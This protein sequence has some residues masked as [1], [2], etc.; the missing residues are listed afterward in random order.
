MKPLHLVYL[1]AA[2]AIALTQP[3]SVLAQGSLTPPGA[4]APT[5]KRLDEVEPRVNLQAVP[6]PTG[7]DS[8]N[9]NYHFIINQPGSYYLSA[10]LGATKANG[11]KINVEGVTLDLNGFEI[12][13]ASG[14]GG[15][16]IEIAATAHRTSLRHGSIKGFLTG[17][18]TVGSAS[19]CSLQGLSVGACMAVGIMAGPSAVLDS[20]RAHDNFQQGIIAGNSATLNN[21]TVTSNFGPAGLQTGSGVTLTNCTA[22]LNLGQDAILAGDGSSIS[23]CSAFNNNGGTSNGI[24]AGPGSTITACSSSNNAGSGFNLGTGGTIQKC[25]A[26][27][28]KADGITLSSGSAARDNDCFSNRASGGSGTGIHATGSDNRI[29]GNNLVNNDRGIDV[30]A[31]NNLIVRNSARRNTTNYDIVAN[32]VYGGIID[33]TAPASA[34]V[35]GNS[36]ATSAGTLDPWANVS[37]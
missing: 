13:R 36:A 24:T 15:N 12:S 6:A 27:F 11:I 17:I 21:C 26:S 10:N 7:V 35:N 37:Y 5:M 14:L 1:V 31:A 4:P 3:S 8:T 20:C 23:N 29:D 2:A 32:N 30:D 9:P 19:A 34:A 25:T 16:G 18:N 22:T 28:N 33:R